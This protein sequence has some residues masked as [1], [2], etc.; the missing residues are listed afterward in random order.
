MKQYF[1]KIGIR[2]HDNIL[3]EMGMKEKEH[4]VFFASAI[5]TSRLLPFFEWLF[6][7]SSDNSFNNIDLDKK[8]PVENSSEYCKTNNH[9]QI[10]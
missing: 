2:E 4:E 1:N 8:H 3:Y 7:W 6:A 5:K 10:K 9:L